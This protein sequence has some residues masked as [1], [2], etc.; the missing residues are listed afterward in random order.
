MTSLS[1]FL[2]FAFCVLALAPLAQAEFTDSEADY[3]E[4]YETTWYFNAAEY[5]QEKGIVDG[6]ED[7]TFQPLNTINRAEFTKI[8]LNATHP[9]AVGGSHCFTDVED[10]WFAPYI[11]GAKT[12][13]IIGGYPDGT[14]LPGDNVNFAEAAKI[15]TN[16]FDIETETTDGAWYEPYVDYMDERYYFPYSTPGIEFSVY[17]G[18]MAEMVYN[19]L[20]Q[21]PTYS[22]A[23]N[24]YNTAP[25][26]WDIV[27]IAVGGSCSYYEVQDLDRTPIEVPDEIETI[28]DCGYEVKFFSEDGRYLYYIKSNWEEDNYDTAERL[29]KVYDLEDGSITTLLTLYDTT[30]NVSSVSWNDSQT[31]FTMAVL[32]FEATDYPTDVKL[33]IL[34]IDGDTLVSKDKYNVSMP[35]DCS[36]NEGCFTLESPTWTSDTTLEYYVCEEQ[37]SAVWEEYDEDLSTVEGCELETLEVSGV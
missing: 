36:S 4:R 34:R 28:F 3:D 5:L 19:F 10:E 9:E 27:R 1:R 18:E 30:A 22:S 13:G 23:V 25:A 33:F 6:Y 37:A 7:G 26:G 8:V 2:A 11:C 17:R 15:L 31:L 35:Y 21:D 24:P 32:N 16:A 14:F 29:F 12:L 20:T